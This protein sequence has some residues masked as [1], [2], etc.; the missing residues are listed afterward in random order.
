MRNTRLICIL[1][2]LSDL[3]SQINHVLI[4]LR[5]FVFL[6]VLRL[7][8]FLIVLRLFVFL[9][10]LRLFVL[11]IVLRLFVIDIRNSPPQ[12]GLYI[13]TMASQAPRFW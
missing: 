12:D 3:S 7:F 10:V 4:V 13:W 6:I 1:V 9:I 8:V 11:L 5:L 2:N